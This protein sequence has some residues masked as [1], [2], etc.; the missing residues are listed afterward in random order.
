MCQICCRRFDRRMTSS[1]VQF[2]AL[3]VFSGLKSLSKHTPELV[4]CRVSTCAA[5]MPQ[6]SDQPNPG[7]LSRTWDLKT[8][9]P[10]AGATLRMP[11]MGQ[12][13][14]LFSTAPRS[15]SHCEPTD[16]TT[17]ALWPL[18]GAGSLVCHES[19]LASPPA[20]RMRCLEHAVH[21]YVFARMRRRHH[22]T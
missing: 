2:F 13:S 6:W 21:A 17:Q 20:L 7:V 8:P 18:R 4:R 10:M 1:L 16:D 11:S 12:L 5:P 14:A 3:E 9:P 19:C 22:L 15:T